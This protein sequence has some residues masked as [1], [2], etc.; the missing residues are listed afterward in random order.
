[1]V[2]R[3]AGVPRAHKE[4]SPASRAF[5]EGFISRFLG[6]V[7]PAAINPILASKGGQTWDR[8]VGAIRPWFEARTSSTRRPLLLTRF[9]QTLRNSL[10]GWKRLAAQMSAIPRPKCAV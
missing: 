3:R 10:R 6:A 8:Y 5:I 1:M 2:A 7:S 4:P 9:A